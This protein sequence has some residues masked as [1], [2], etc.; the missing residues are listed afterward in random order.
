MTYEEA[1]QVLR[2]GEIALTLE[3]LGLMAR[4]EGPKASPLFMSGLR[5][6]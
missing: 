5:D 6:A 1:V 3:I 2:E 4:A